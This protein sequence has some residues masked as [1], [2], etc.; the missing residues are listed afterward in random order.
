MALEP[1]NA[2]RLGVFRRNSSCGISRHIGHSLIGQG[3]NQG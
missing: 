1:Q 2:A 3:G